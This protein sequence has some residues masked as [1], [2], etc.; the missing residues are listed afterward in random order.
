MM[1]RCP[2]R[3]DA[4]K[5]VVEPK[6]KSDPSDVHSSIDAILSRNAFDALEELI[7]GAIGS[8]EGTWRASPR[9]G[10]PISI[11][12]GMHL[13]IAKPRCPADPKREWTEGARRCS[14]PPVAIKVA[15]TDQRAVNLPFNDVIR[16]F[17][18]H[19]SEIGK[20]KVKHLTSRSKFLNR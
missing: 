7:M 1:Y 15:A 9:H 14:G 11:H 20:T 3:P 16:Q 17:F 13:T 18:A 10:D 2:R 12:N 6:S 4:R 5:N 19:A 8:G